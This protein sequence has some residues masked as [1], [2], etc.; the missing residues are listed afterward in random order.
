MEHT[1]SLSH[2]HPQYLFVMVKLS[3]SIYYDKLI[4]HFD[5]IFKLI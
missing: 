4:K 1:F 2:T 5:E 3:N